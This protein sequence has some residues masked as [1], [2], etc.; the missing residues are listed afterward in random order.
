MAD[1]LLYTTTTKPPLGTAPSLFR[2]TTNLVNNIKST[3][4]YKSAAH[5][6]KSQ[7]TPLPT[8]AISSK[9]YLPTGGFIGDFRSSSSTIP[10]ATCNDLKARLKLRHDTRLAEFHSE[11]NQIHLQ[12]RSDCS[13]LS[14]QLQSNFDCSDAVISSY[15]TTL[16][17]E[18]EKGS[19]SLVEIEN[20]ENDVKSHYITRE[21]LIGQYN[22]DLSRLDQ[23]R[24]SEISKL[25][26]VVLIDLIDVGFQPPTTIQRLIKPQIDQLN[27]ALIES[28]KEIEV[29]VQELYDNLSTWKEEINQSLSRIRQLW[30]QSVVGFLVEQFKTLIESPEVQK[31]KIWVENCLVTSVVD[32]KFCSHRLLLFEE[33]FNLEANQ[34]LPPFVDITGQKLIDLGST[35]ESK[36]QELINYLSQSNEEK[37][38]NLRLQIKK[39][40]ELVVS[41]GANSLEE[42]QNSVEKPGL[43]ILSDLQSNYENFV[44]SL[45]SCF[46]IFDNISIDQSNFYHKYLTVLSIKISDH[47]TMF[48]Q[49]YLEFSSEIS[50]IFYDYYSIIQENE[51][52]IANILVKISEASSESA[53]F[54]LFSQAKSCLDLIGNCYVETRQKVLQ[55]QQDHVIKFEKFMDQSVSDFCVFFGLSLK[56]SIIENEVTKK[57]TENDKNQS[58]RKKSASSK[59]ESRDQNLM[60]AQKEQEK[61]EIVTPD[62]SKIVLYVIKSEDQLFS[63]NHDIPALDDVPLVHSYIIPDSILISRI[64][65]QKIQ[66]MTFLFTQK[67]ENLQKLKA[68][69][70]ESD[71]VLSPKVE[72]LLKNLR[73][74]Y[75]LIELNNVEKR[76]FSLQKIQSKISRQLSHLDQ[77]HGSIIKILESK[78]KSVQDDLQSFLTTTDNLT[79]SLP[80]LSTISS[81]RR[82]KSKKI[83]DFENLETR[84]SE[85]GPMLSSLV[86][87]TVENFAVDNKTFLDSFKISNEILV[88]DDHLHV[89]GQELSEKVM[90]IQEDLTRRLQSSNDVIST[91]FDKIKSSFDLFKSMIPHHESELSFLTTLES[92]KQS[93]HNKIT[94]ITQKLSNLIDGLQSRIN[95]LVESRSISGSHE[96]LKFLFIFYLVSIKSWKVVNYLD[97]WKESKFDLIDLSSKVKTLDQNFENL[98][99]DFDPVDES[100]PSTA[101]SPFKV[102]VETII[103]DCISKILNLYTSSFDSKFQFARTSIPTSV[104]G[105]Q[106]ELEF[107]QSNLMEKINLDYENFVTKFYP[108]VDNSAIVIE[109]SM[110]KIFAE[111]FENNL[112][113][114]KDEILEISKNLQLS[115]EKGRNQLNSIVQNIRPAHKL[116]KLKSE[117]DLIVD[118]KRDLIKSL[119]DS[120]DSCKLSIK[121]RL[122]SFLA[123]KTEEISHLINF[124]IVILTNLPTLLDL[125]PNFGAVAIGTLA[126][127]KN[128][129]QVLIEK[130]NQKGSLLSEVAPVKGKE[131][132]S[133][134]SRPFS[135]MEFPGLS[136]EISVLSNTF[137]FEIAKM[138]GLWSSPLHFLTFSCLDV[139][140]KKLLNWFEQ[141]NL[142]LGPNIAQSEIFVEKLE[143]QWSECLEALEAL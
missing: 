104:K 59:I 133:T 64:F 70:S 136:C 127:Q 22:S 52:L 117:F 21:N 44:L 141:L 134:F 137:K 14:S 102:T 17:K 58:K 9:E 116:P 121:S 50:M 74:R 112:S 6:H 33:I 47:L 94:S 8:P 73:R 56:P 60:D 128:I 106:S 119:E 78:R 143:V 45:K 68:K 20:F 95:Q 30:M 105:L 124:F 115:C 111:I 90:E 5:T 81:L 55:S 89:I 34:I 19:G 92:S 40:V 125:L 39:D 97:L 7:P 88:S 126:K 129:R 98:I 63:T 61:V 77:K 109:Q 29:V 110:N 26:E 120:V 138:S 28:R 51:N 37:I 114:F 27:I 142:E 41:I 123:E 43:L 16:G 57:N 108:L 82:L 13:S 2:T 38:E 35:V 131:S 84:I 107:W 36:H 79:E 85:F 62:Q 49:I 93:A 69:I 4:S 99:D 23:K 96:S 53:L 118:R 11:V 132:N 25:V 10:G 67:F 100:L 71:Q 130:S 1:R 24:R 80:T 103:N 3:N 54:S 48:N 113:K 66:V 46:Q 65:S 101:I 15:F 31:P 91:V 135:R 122:Q 12:F 42:A 140:F 86:Q 139:Q 75:F 76:S 83:I 32:R 72:N 18:F 87:S